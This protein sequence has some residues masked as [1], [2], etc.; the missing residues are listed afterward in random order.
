[1]SLLGLFKR[2]GP[3]GFGY[4]S[5]A[6]D[7]TE[8]L[9]LTG[10]TVVITGCNSGL[11]LESMRVL[12]SRGATV[13]GLARDEAKARAAC[14]SVG[15]KTIP[16]ACELEDLASVRR[17]VEAIRGTGLRLNAVVANAG[18][19]AL[20]SLETVQGV[21][22]QLFTNH[23]GHFVLVTGLLDQ[24]ADDGRVV[25]LSSM[26][27]TMAPK[28]GI[29]LDNLDGSRGYDAWKAYGQSKLANLLFAR[30]LARRF[31]GS[32]RVALAVH[33]G[34][35]ATNLGRHMNVVMRAAGAM[36]GWLF[37]KTEPQGAATEVWAAVHPDAA[38]HNGAYLSD[39]NVEAS[40]KAGDDAGLG[41]RLWA[42]TEA[43]VAR[44][45]PG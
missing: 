25:V 33:P 40:S 22:R 10:R 20:P 6:S 28:V 29:E 45:S 43:I 35:I 5:T 31:E 13:I 26:A 16:V 15:G 19:M 7:V 18:I 44:V 9:D 23:V 14:G 4:S 17:A 42:A 39:C 27:H 11:G 1:M 30:S 3:S 24:L 34:V 21:E 2:P 41:D 36:F 38:K 32:R 37:L 12:A 8:G